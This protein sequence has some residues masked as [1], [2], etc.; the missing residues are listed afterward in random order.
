MTKH[1]QGLKGNEFSSQCRS[2]FGLLKYIDVVNDPI[3]GQVNVKGAVQRNRKMI[4]ALST[5]DSDRY[6]FQQAS[7][8]EGQSQLPVK[9]Q[10]K[11]IKTDDFSLSKS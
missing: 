10:S 11:T 2:K 9:F 5:S 6:L 7:S 3:D 8:L 4:N 1:Q